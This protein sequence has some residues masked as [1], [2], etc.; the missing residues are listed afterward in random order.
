[1]I[2]STWVPEKKDVCYF[3]IYILEIFWLS[4][5]L[6]GQ[7]RVTGN[8]M[9]REMGK[10]RK[11]DLGSDSNPGVSDQ[12]VP[13]TQLFLRSVWCTC[14]TSSASVRSQTSNENGVRKTS[15]ML[16]YIELQV[17]LR[18][19]KIPRGKLILS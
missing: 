14:R 5:I 1:M 6:I 18:R 17:N 12:S 9:E 2:Y 19:K 3:F 4:F 13:P 11:K 15:V 10:D 7:S 8:Q 16:S